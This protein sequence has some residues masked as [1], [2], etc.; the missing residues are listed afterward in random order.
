MGH[1]S[2]PPFDRMR[3]RQSHSTKRQ[4]SSL[5][6]RSFLGRF[7]RIG[8]APRIAVHGAFEVREKAPWHAGQ[9][10]QRR[11]PTA[12]FP[13]Q[14]QGESLTGLQQAFGPWG[15]PWPVWGCRQTTRPAWSGPEPSVG[16]PHTPAASAPAPPW[17]TAGSI[18]SPG[19]PA[20]ET[21]ESATRAGLA[22]GPWPARP[23][24]RGGRPGRPPAGTAAPGGVVP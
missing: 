17:T 21:W 4:G 5:M 1:G 20:P 23:G 11:A 14:G 12:P 15:A 7:V 13:E 18:P 3:K 8:T 16:G 22:G 2:N 6:V 10:R 19:H 24:R 9:G